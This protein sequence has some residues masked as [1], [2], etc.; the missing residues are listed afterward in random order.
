MPKRPKPRT[1]RKPSKPPAT[2]TRAKTE[3]K[4][5]ARDNA[6][7]LYLG[8]FS[9]D[10]PGEIDH[11]G[12]FQV[13]V[14][15]STPKQAVTRLR[16]RLRKL[17]SETSHFDSPT[18]IY[19]DGLVRLAGSFKDG[20][21]VNYVSRQSAENDVQIFCTVPEQPGS[22]DV[23][24]YGFGEE[25]GDVEAF[26]DFGGEA[27]RKALRKAKSTSGAAQ[28]NAP[29]RAT[30][31]RRPARSKDERDAERREI[32]ARKSRRAEE[33]AARKMQEE[34]KRRAR[35]NRKSALSETLAELGSR[36]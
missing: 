31:P 34:R 4:S 27:F 11:A 30:Q 7:D 3:P 12:S 16:A 36:K 35:E 24:S 5:E 28:L 20:L 1:S 13:I 33:S 29:I 18:T 10:E 2:R 19:C 32:D 26:L 21:L 15:A 22:Q 23:D 14:E 6:E 17:R 8:C 9:T 25:E